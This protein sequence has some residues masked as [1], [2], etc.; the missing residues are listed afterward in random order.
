MKEI[1]RRCTPG[2]ASVAYRFSVSLAQKR[3]SADREA[4][5][6]LWTS[7]KRRAASRQVACAASWTMA[8]PLSTAPFNCGVSGVV[9]PCRMPL[10]SHN[11]KAPPLNSPPPPDRTHSTTDDLVLS[12]TSEINHRNAAPKSDVLLRKYVQPKR[13]KYSLMSIM[14]RAPAMDRVGFGSDRLANTRCKG[15]SER[16]RV[17]FLRGW[18]FPLGMEHPPQALKSFVKWKPSCLAVSCEI[19]GWA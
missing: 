12:R 14:Y 17:V 9:N 4:F 13:E 8:S 1:P 15:R 7:G 11:L 18:S 2:F 16:E 10:S 3:A 19:P 5:A 6:G